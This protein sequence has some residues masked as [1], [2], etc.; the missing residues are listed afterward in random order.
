MAGPQQRLAIARFALSLGC[1]C[2][3]DNK[4]SIVKASRPHQ[5]LIPAT[6]QSLIQRELQGRERIIL[7]FLGKERE[8]GPKLEV[9]A[10]ISSYSL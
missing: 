6:A 5:G 10:R 3:G 1:L 9:V 2:L 7:A 4:T 8:K